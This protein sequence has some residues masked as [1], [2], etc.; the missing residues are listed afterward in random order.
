MAGVNGAEIKP[1]SD[2]YKNLLAALQQAGDPFVRLRVK[3]FRPAHLRFAGKIKIKPDY[4]ADLVVAEVERA[5]RAQ[6]SFTLRAFG[7]PVFLSE[8]I[9]VVQAV[10]GV[11]ATDVDKLYRS[12]S[13]ATLETRLLAALPEIGANGALVGA[14]LL[15][16]D[17]APLDSLGV[18]S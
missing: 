4:Q 8:V 9:A 16:L 13:T 14:E 1:E 17:D 15:T 6:F 18:M 7:Q 3:S 2:T 5:L 10:S 11:L 12:G